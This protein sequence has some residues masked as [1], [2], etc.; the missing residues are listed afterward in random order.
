MYTVNRNVLDFDFEKVCSVTLSNINV[1]VCL[2]CGKYFQGMFSRLF[3][4]FFPNGFF[5]SLLGRGRN[6]PAFVH[7]HQADHHVF[8]KMET[9]KAYCLPD[10]YEIIDSSL[11]DIR[12]YLLLNYIDQ[13]VLLHPIL[14]GHSTKFD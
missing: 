1:Y 14:E 13:S 3:T 4:T 12:V 7:S 5:P 11:N 2:V 6:T 8:M 9:L 10:G